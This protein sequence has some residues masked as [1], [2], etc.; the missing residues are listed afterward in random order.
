MLGS[1]ESSATNKFLQQG[2]GHHYQRLGAVFDQHQ[3]IRA[4]QPGLQRPPPFGPGSGLHLDSPTTPG[5]ISPQITSK[6]TAGPTRERHFNRRDAGFFQSFS[7][8]P[9]ST[10]ALIA[11]R[12]TRHFQSS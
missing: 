3:Q 9:L 10:R 11:G 7:Y 8:F 5:D 1:R 12:F 6:L 4:S 2:E